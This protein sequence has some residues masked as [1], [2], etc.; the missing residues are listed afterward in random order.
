MVDVKGCDS[1]TIPA[2]SYLAGIKA[3]R[4]K[5]SAI[6]PLILAM[7]NKLS[8]RIIFLATQ[9]AVSNDFA[10]M[11]SHLVTPAR[12]ESPAVLGP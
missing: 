11:C 3:V 5:I 1:A 6:C 10:P 9:P 7:R 2:N 4:R 8:S 12:D